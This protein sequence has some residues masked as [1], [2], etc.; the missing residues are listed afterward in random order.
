M[1]SVPSST[2]ADKEA[3]YGSSSNLVQSKYM[4][5]YNMRVYSQDLFD[6]EIFESNSP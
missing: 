1:L 2:M 3:E 4:G 6:T 5:S